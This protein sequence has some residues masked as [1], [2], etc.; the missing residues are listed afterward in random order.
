M[1]Y[2]VL[3]AIFILFLQS[4]IIIQSLFRSKHEIALLRKIN[5]AVKCFG[6]G[7]A[8]CCGA[9]IVGEHDFCEHKKGVLYLC[10]WEDYTRFKK[11]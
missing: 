1:I 3:I 11:W 9:Q 4:V 10:G 2:L 6:C 8:S 7:T 5:A